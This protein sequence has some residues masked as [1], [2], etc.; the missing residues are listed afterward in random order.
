MTNVESTP[1]N[2]LASNIQFGRFAPNGL[3]ESDV[4]LCDHD[5]RMVELWAG[6]DE[7]DW[8]VETVHLDEPIEREDFN[9]RPYYFA[10]HAIGQRRED[11][12]APLSLTPRSAP[13]TNPEA[14]ERDE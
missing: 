6:N 13:A 7:G 12:G 8:L 1:P 14:V 10:L 2:K 3:V 11:C 9:N 4:H 5:N